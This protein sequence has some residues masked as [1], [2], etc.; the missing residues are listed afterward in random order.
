[1][2]IL[3]LELKVKNWLNLKKQNYRIGKVKLE[4]KGIRWALHAL[5][6]RIGK[7]KLV[8]TG[9]RWAT[10]TELSHNYR[11]GFSN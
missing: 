6:Y 10:C 2:V 5:N 11:I 7:V 9:I 3:Y 4:D 1:M 8:D